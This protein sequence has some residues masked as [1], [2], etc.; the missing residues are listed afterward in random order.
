MVLALDPRMCVFCQP[1]LGLMVANF[2]QD[3]ACTSSGQHEE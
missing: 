3:G 1:S 2:I